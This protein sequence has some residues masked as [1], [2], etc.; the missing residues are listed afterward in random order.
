MIISIDA[1]KAFDKI[2]HPF[3]LKTLKKLDIS[4]IYLKIRAIYDKPTANIMLNG[5]KL[6]ASPLKTATR[7]AYAFSP[8]L[9]NIVF[10]VLVRAIRQEKEIKGTQIGRE[11]V[12]L[13]LQITR[14]YFLKTLLS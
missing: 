10:D 3:M 5:Q 9:S 13:F 7:Q 2:K 1:E 11:K 12:K 8:L 4:G 14:F 6:E